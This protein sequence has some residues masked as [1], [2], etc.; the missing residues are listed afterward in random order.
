MVK[1]GAR[2][3]SCWDSMETDWTGRQW[4]WKFQKVETL[5]QSHVEGEH[6]RGWEPTGRV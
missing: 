3:K 4:G 1:E 2:R 5:G 6:G